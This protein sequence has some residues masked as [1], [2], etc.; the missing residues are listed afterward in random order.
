MCIFHG[1]TQKTKDKN[2]FTL[3]WEK[4]TLTHQKTHPTGPKSQVKDSEVTA[5]R[6]KEDK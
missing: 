5:R 6:E 4:K 3:K 2:G 1:K